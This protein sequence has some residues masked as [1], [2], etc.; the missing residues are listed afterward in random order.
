MALNVG[1]VDVLVVYFQVDQRDISFLKTS[2]A[3]S[4]YVTESP[5]V[6]L[7]YF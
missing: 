7:H 2:V 5:F 3:C 1:G 6:H 4:C